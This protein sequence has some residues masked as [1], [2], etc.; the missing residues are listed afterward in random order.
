NDKAERW[1]HILGDLIFD[2]NN[3][4]I[5]MI[6]TIQD[7]T[8]RKQSEEERKFLIAAVENSDSIVTVKDLNLRVVAANQAFI[9]STRHSS[10]KSL[11][12]K[13]DA[14]IYEI[15]A[16]SEPVR[17]YME[18]ERKAQKLKP[19]EF[20]L[21]EEPLIL[22][23]GKEITILTRK[24]PIFDSE[25]KLFCTGNVSTNIT[26]LKKA[27]EA[28]WLKNISFDSAIA[29]NIITDT[30]GY[31]NEANEAFL[32]IFGYRTKNEVV[33]R[34]ILN[35]VY[36]IAE[37]QT[38]ISNLRENGQ[39]EGDY[40][41]KKVDGSTF[42]AHS[43]ATCMKNKE[44]K[45]IGYQASV[46]DIT[47]RKR[48]EEALRESEQMLQTVLD[49]F[50]GV[51]FWKDRQSNYLG[52]NQAFATAAGLNS[53]SEIVGK[54]DF[55]LPWGETEGENYRADDLE[56]MEKEF[57]KLH[58]IETQHQADGKVIWFDTSK[59]PLRE[60]EGKVIGVIGVSSD[61][62]DRKIVEDALIESEEKYRTIAN[63]TNDWEYW[64]DPN[65]NFLYCSPSCERISG[66]N[67]M[68]FIQNPKLLAQI[69]HP[70]DIKNYLKHKQEQVTHKSDEE[71]Q[72]RIFRFDGQER[73]IGHVYQPVFNEIGEYIGIRG[74]NRDIT[75]RKKTEEKLKNSER[76]YMLLS[77]NITDGV[78]TCRNG[79]VEY[80]NDSMSRIFG[81]E[82]SELEG[83]KLSQLVI[84]ER[85]NDFETFISV[86]PTT[87][88]TNN[89]D[90]ECVRKDGSTVFAEIFLNYVASE[91]LI[92]GV[93]HDITEKRLIQEKK[94]IQAIIQT[95]ENERAHFSKEL[96]DGLGPL[97][98]T[99]KLYLQWS[100]RPKSNRSREEIILKAEEILEEALTAVKE[101]SNKLSPHLLTNYGLTSAVQSFANKLQ[102]TN[103]IGIDFRSN[104]TRRVEMETEVA[105]YRAIIECI[106]NTIKHAEAK[107]IYIILNDAGNQLQLQ[108]RDDGKGF[109]IV[110]ILL[111]KK[112]LGLFNLQNRIQ[113]IG[114]E[115]KLFSK[116][117]E[118]VNYHINV[119]VKSIS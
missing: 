109:D 18:D 104:L 64:L 61:I 86:E 60:P 46:I 69:M 20:I 110:K 103:T 29:A 63:F 50:P 100:I 53:P 38:I 26:V 78:F 59:I 56:V 107:H 1:V 35:F 80:V 40:I 83:L 85:R 54:T 7:I 113:T 8:E 43:L 68:E 45:I 90:I 91:E 93:M 119:P 9:N 94:V 44:G 22:P 75:E 71:L 30:N 5:N 88:Q 15:P 108:Y 28:L 48:A 17:T 105:L 12:G 51:V 92:Y 87:N 47:D 42:T 2:N 72:F 4:P 36:D 52:C 19:G 76:K 13:T 95:E 10:I 117:H 73:W 115:I 77:K 33:G 27:E 11:I 14:E 112:G 57:T 116:P 21:R 65:D 114:G 79:Y 6:G 81:Y 37:G 23:N 41:A 97:L 101:I 96:H 102:E 99:I 31:T 106:N 98:S 24:Y 70:G 32:R 84:P 39:W 111:N 89:I 55:Q 62:T 16:D 34:S 25:G 82:E 3:H 67:A 66:Y 58:I 49:H 74:S 118:G